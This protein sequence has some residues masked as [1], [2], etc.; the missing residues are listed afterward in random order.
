[1]LKAGK[2]KDRACDGNVAEK[3][4]KDQRA[5]GWEQKKKRRYHVQGVEPKVG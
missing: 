4:L 1:M 5:T 3:Y 2:W